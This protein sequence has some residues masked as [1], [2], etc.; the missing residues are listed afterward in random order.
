[1]NKF[2]V[3]IL[4]VFGMFAVSPANGQNRSAR[5]TQNVTINVT[6]RGYRPSSFRLKKGIRTRLTFI[7]KVDET[8]GTEVVIP[9]LNIRRDLPLNQP[10][11][12]VFTP[13]RSGTFSFACGMNMLR[14]K[15]IV[16]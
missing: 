5:H 1:M 12:V 15:L 11:T 7:R 2:F 16:S 6:S 10:V 4:V 3:L 14:G 9:S 8:C 13:R